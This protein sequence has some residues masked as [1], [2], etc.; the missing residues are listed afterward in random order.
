MLLLQIGA[1]NA[2]SFF[3]GAVVPTVLALVVEVVAAVALRGSRPVVARGIGWGILISL[4]PVAGL[5][6]V[7]GACVALLRF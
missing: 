1:T 2:T 7:F 6:L 3:V 4:I 5:A